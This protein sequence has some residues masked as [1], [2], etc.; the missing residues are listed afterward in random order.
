M[1]ELPADAFEDSLVA[2]QQGEFLL[3]YYHHIMAQGIRTR[4][5]ANER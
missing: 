1:A 2:S 5:Q 3:G 4:G